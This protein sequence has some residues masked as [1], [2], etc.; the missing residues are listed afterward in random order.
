MHLLDLLA[1][2]SVP[3]AG[4]S[5]GVTRRCPLHCEHCSTSSTMDSEQLDADVLE[6]FVA[7]F[8][9]TSHPLLMALSG[10]EAL[11]RPELV[12]RLVMKAKE[13]GTRSSVLSGLFFAANGGNIPPSIQRVIDVVDHFS[14]STDIYH[15]KEVPREAVFQV[16][17]Q[18][19]QQGKDLSMHVAGKNPDD[20]YLEE[21][22]HDVERRFGQR[23][24]MLINTLS[25]FGRG[26]ALVKVDAS[27]LSKFSQDVSAN[28]CTMAAWPVVGFDGVVAACGNDNLI[29][30]VPDHL[31]LG[32]IHS[33]GWPLIEARCRERTLL[34]AL[35]VY[36]PLFIADRFDAPTC[37]GYCDTCIGMGQQSEAFDE[38]VSRMEGPYLSAMERSVIEIQQELGPVAFAGRYTH[39][40]FAELVLRGVGS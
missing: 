26:K 36:G 24:P 33:D 10:G 18:L 12:Y 11:L 21:I 22:V 25:A 19:L 17:E 29:G 28:P 6:Q 23:I 8:T 39:P 4:V 38:L 9:R 13:V 14:V 16:L 2:R 32:D 15:E 3:A 27:R 5:I 35:R 20:P 31:R 7:S 34:K 40:R 1:S 30:Q 37:G